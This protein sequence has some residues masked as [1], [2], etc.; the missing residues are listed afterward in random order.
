MNQRWRSGWH[1]LKKL[2]VP[3]FIA[4]LIAFLCQPICVADGKWDLPMLALL[5][6]IPFGIQKMMVWFV[7]RG[8][9]IGGTVAMWVFNILVGGFIGIFVFGFRI[10]C[11]AAELIR[12]LL[13]GYKNHAECRKDTY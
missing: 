3:L 6:G 10:V 12:E 7:P 11:G 2:M 13:G 9:G 8:L 5:V 4:A 1:A